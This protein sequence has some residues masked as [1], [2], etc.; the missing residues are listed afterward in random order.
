MPDV[1]GFQ[2]RD[3]VGLSSPVV[4]ITGALT[5]IGRA[6]ALN[7]AQEGAHL[8]VSGCRDKEGKELAAEL[9]GLG[10]EAIFVRTEVRNENEVQDLVDKTVAR[11]GR[12]DAAVN[13]LEL[14]QFWPGDGT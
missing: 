12:L 6:A 2:I 5:G 7:F 14:W 4:W 13:C 8:V 1:H 11:F 10:P 3:V 9:Q